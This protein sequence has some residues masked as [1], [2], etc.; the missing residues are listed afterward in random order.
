MSYTIH[1]IVCKDETVP[2]IYVGSTAD[3][4]RRRTSHK[5]HSKDEKYNTKL[6]NTIRANG[7]FKYWKMEVVEYCTCNTVTDARIRERF[8]FDQ[9]QANLNSIRPQ[10]NLKEKQMHINELSK[11]YRSDN[12]EIISD[13]K[14]TKLC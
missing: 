13:N 2:G 1:K 9:L 14:K 5:S 11:Q 10:L 4:V 6:Y 7:G 8:Y 3:F 12:K